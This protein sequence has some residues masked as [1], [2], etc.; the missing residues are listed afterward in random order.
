MIN[1]VELI[2]ISNNGYGIY[3]TPTT[4]FFAYNNYGLGFY[5][6]LLFSNN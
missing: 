6:S 1:N 2:Q 5:F 3:F 4:T